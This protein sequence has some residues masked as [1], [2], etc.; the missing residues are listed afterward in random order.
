MS[1][2]CDGSQPTHASFAS[3]SDT[4]NAAEWNGD[5]RESL[6]IKPYAIT[7]AVSVS[8]SKTGI[9]ATI[10]SSGVS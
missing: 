10:A 5:Q 1:L 9:F 7:V 6:G 8:P 3:D 2:A 4:A